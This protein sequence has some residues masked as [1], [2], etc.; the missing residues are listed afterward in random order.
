MHGAEEKLKKK[1]RNSKIQKVILNSL[2]IAGVLSM[3]ALTP[4]AVSLLKHLDPDKKKKYQKYGINNAIK[5]LCAK[6]LIAWEKNGSSVF[7][8]LTKEGE[9]AI[10]ILERNEFKVIVPKKW[11]G[12]WRIIIFDI[13]E[14]KKASRD[15][16]R[17][18]LQKIGFLKLQNS[19]W[20]YPYNC[21]ELI[22]LIKA[23]FMMGK[24]ILYIIADS[25]EHDRVVRKYFKLPKS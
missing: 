24:E 15:K 21:E 6:G 4:N 9:R 25:I 7:L 22:A 13:H 20:V 12:K 19:V 5:R 1:I 8:R 17:L 10:E 11:D 16:F 2:Y 3:A 23:D 18:I 14:T